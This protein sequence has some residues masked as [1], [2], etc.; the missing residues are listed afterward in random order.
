M[1]G[2]GQRTNRALLA[3]RVTPTLPVQALGSPRL[4]PLTW[5]PLSV[6]TWDPHLLLHN[7]ISAQ[8]HEQGPFPCHT[9]TSKTEASRVPLGPPNMHYRYVCMYIYLYIDCI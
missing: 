5:S 6:L 1:W 7:R 4:G 2:A 9:Q 3:S 8:K